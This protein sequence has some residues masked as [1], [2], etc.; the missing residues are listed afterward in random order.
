MAT[1]N[2]EPKLRLISE[3]TMLERNDVF[4]IPQYQRAYSWTISHCTKLWQDIEDFIDSSAEDPYFFGTIIIDCSTA[5][6][7]SLIDGQQRTTTFF[8][9]LKALQLRLKELLDNFN[10]S[11]DT[12][13]LFMGLNRS[14]DTIC[15]ILYKADDDKQVE[16]K[17]NWNNARGITILENNSINELYKNDFRMIIEAENFKEAE[18]SVYKF[19]R[20]QKDNKY[21]NFF[22]NFKYFFERISEYSESNLNN[23]AKIFL[24]KCQIIEIKSWQIEQAITMFNS[25]NSTGMPL[26]DADIISAQLYS[27]AGDEERNIFVDKWHDINV[28]ADELAQKKIVNIDGV[29][30]QFMYINRAAKSHYKLNEVTTPGLRKYYLIEHPELLNEPLLIC[31]SFRKILDIWNAIKDYPIIKLLLKFNENFKLFLISYLFRYN[32]SAL[33]KDI[34][35]P[36]A[37]CLLRLFTIIEVGDAGYSA[38]KFKTFLFNENF[39][40]VDSSYTLDQIKEDFDKHI[41]NTWTRKDLEDDLREYSKNVIVYLNEYIYAKEQNRHYNIDEK[42]NVE[43][44]MP[45]SGHNIEVIRTDAGIN[46]PEEFSYLVNQLGNKILLEEVINKTIGNDWFRTKKVGPLSSK[47]GYVGSSFG[48]ALDLAKY[49]KDR[50]EKE[51]I[52]NATNAAIERISKFVFKA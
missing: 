46:D 22:R 48:F 2:I 23:F 10:Y 13:A 29:L 38:S 51:D 15:R 1:K 33:T 47:T 4:E 30:Q 20:K 43:H 26:S 32:A 14:Y 8:L 25:L 27:K 39:N 50:W 16:M 41:N 7:L 36:F 6:H 52:E 42:T 3:Y 28:I 31:D 49:P 17:N 18:C 40:L 19:P 21:T 11:P 24:S 44:I 9:L 37:E 12:A 34:V 35:T 45:A 5:N